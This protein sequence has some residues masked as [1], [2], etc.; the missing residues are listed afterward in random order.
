MCV[1]KPHIDGRKKKGRKKKKTKRKLLD[2]WRREINYRQISPFF[3]LNQSLSSLE[4][5]RRKI[6][7]RFRTESF[8]LHRYHFF[9]FLI[10]LSRFFKP[11][12]LLVV[13]FAL[14]SFDSSVYQ[15]GKW[16]RQRWNIFR[17]FT[18]VTFC[19]SIVLVYTIVFSTK[20]PNT[21]A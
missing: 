14:V 15:C 5:I 11:L 20:K 7:K 12:R 8:L 18:F 4:N 17:F 21:D 9:P 3:F 16:S 2:K 13:T 19:S 1:E 10:H 6:S